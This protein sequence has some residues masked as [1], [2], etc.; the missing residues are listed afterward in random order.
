V[1]LGSFGTG[2]PRAFGG[3]TAVVYHPS[4]AGVTFIA[5]TE[6]LP[7]G[8]F[9]VTLANAEDTLAWAYRIGGKPPLP[10]ASKDTGTAIGRLHLMVDGVRRAIASTAGSGTIGQI[11]AAYRAIDVEIRAED[12]LFGL[13]VRAPLQRAPNSP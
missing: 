6:T 2:T 7:A 11:L 8:R 12:D 10:S 1:L 3:R 9:L 5:A 4:I 13:H